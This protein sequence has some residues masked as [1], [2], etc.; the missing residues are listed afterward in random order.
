MYAT[1]KEALN[2]FIQLESASG[3]LIL[4]SAVMAILLEN[5]PFSFFYNT[6]LTQKISIL[7]NG[8]GI[9]KPVLLWINDGL[10]AVFFLLVSLEIKREILEGQLS[11]VSKASLPFVAALGGMIIP[12]LIYTLLNYGDPIAM[13]GWA[14]PVATDIAFAICLVSFL[15]AKFVPRSLRTF[16]LAVAIIDDL[17][18]IS[19]IAFFYTGALSMVSIGVALSAF[20]VLCMLNSANV[21]RISFYILVGI[22]LWVAVLKSGVHATLAGVLVAL[23]IPI[24]IS[25]TSHSPLKNLENMLHPWIVYGI[26]P[27]FAFA[28]AGVSFRG[29][30]VLDLL[31]PLPLGIILGLTLGKTMGIFSF[32]YMSVKCKLC[33]LPPMSNWGS[34]LGIA[35]TC[36]IGFTMSLF[37]GTLAF[38]TPDLNRYVRMG[39]LIG[40][41][42]SAVGGY[43]ILRL[44]SGKGRKI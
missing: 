18:A 11:S 5:S 40:S 28:N 39:V 24:K 12:A 7:M 17:A 30:S 37:I 4:L 9:E 3:I 20:I 31:H 16:L 27:L 44:S 33:T 29:L 36:G 42:L 35:I 10:M 43:M 26:M 15:G 41:T 34:I 1:A 32:V 2:K 19:I 8:Y 21:Q 13:K 23:T 14:I 38:D 6:L 22:I 25:K